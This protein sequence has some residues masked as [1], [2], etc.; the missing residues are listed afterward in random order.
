MSVTERQ[1]WTEKLYTLLS[2]PMRLEELI[3]A[4][5][6]VGKT[7]LKET[8]DQWIKQGKICK[9]KKNRYAQAAHFGC[10]TGTFLATSRGFGFV[11][12]DTADEQPPDKANDIFIPPDECGD[13]WHKDRV[14]VQCTS[15]KNAY[16]RREGTV[17]RVL[18]RAVTELNGALIKMSR[19]YY[20]SPSNTKYPMLAL[21]NVAPNVEEGEL[22]AVSITEYGT[23]GKLPQAEIIA[24]L[25]KAGTLEASVAGILRENGIT[26]PFSTAA[27]EQAQSI[28]QTVTDSTGR[29]DLR[30]TLV[31]TIDGDDAR[32]F[33]DAVSLEKL[34]N[35]RML[36]GVHIADV[37]HY[38]TPDSPLDEEAFQRGASVYYPGRVIPMLPFALSNGI[39]SLNPNVDRFAFSVLLEVDKDGR[40]HDTRFAK[41]IICSRAR[42]TYRKVNQILAGDQE[43]R[44]E[45]D[46]LV[47]TLEAMN[48]LAHIFYQK[49][50]QRG[51]LELEIPETSIIVDEKG[52]PTNIQ[53]R[54]RGESEH[55][56]EEF[57][58]QANEA[59]AE[60]MCRR[61]Q[62]TV[63]RVHESPAPDKLR[64]FAQFARL[65][66]YRIDPSKPEDTFQ[67]QAILRGAKNDPEQRALPTLLLRSL[68]R[69]RYAEHCIGHYGLKAKFYLHFTSPIRRYP[70]LIAHR[71]LQKSL[72]NEVF[73]EAD[74][75]MCAQGAQQSTVRE[76]AADTAERDID[77]LFIA[78]YMKQFIGE[79][80]DAMVSGIQPYGLF[81]ALENGCEGLLR[82][83]LLENDLYEYDEEHLVMKGKYTGRRFTI[84][85]SL[86]VRLIAASEVTGQVDFSMSD[87]ANASSSMKKTHRA[88]KPSAPT[89]GHNRAAR[90]KKNKNR[91]RSSGS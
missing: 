72:L 5:P 66:N 57:M 67:L 4:M 62:P 61:E 11:A 48:Q 25:G 68:A 32:D 47:E 86:R 49:R 71:M 35:G 55:L 30:Q 14:L 28:P 85:M 53:Y 21:Q 40:C 15:E 76:M 74:E 73:T 50:I 31:F 79:E 87:T 77:K 17:L 60:Y 41:S 91:R 2:S 37:S 43:L 13:A 54:K 19:H 22:V 36:L 64:A 88:S 34:E 38:V 44:A 42:M 16:G 56:I 23:G 83:E 90:R 51:A 9:N 27:L 58:L 20:V 82:V 78:A 39:C 10:F 75:E 59:V 33:D 69:A 8:L 63:Y 29:L 80:F 26:E 70:D 52:Q 45:Y 84:G 7:E 3:R 1:E 46:F 65:F 18:S 24:P 89:H 6:E 12:P 81:V